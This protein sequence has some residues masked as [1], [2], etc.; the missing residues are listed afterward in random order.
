VATPPG[1]LSN[2]YLEN[3]IGG[4]IHNATVLRPAWAEQA[5]GCPWPAAGAQTP[6]QHPLSAPLASTRWLRGGTPIP[7]VYLDQPYAQRR[8][9]ILRMD[10]TMSSHPVTFDSSARRLGYAFS[11]CIDALALYVVNHFLEWGVPVVTPAFA[12]ALW[13]LNLSLVTAIVMN[14]TF[15]GYDA[16]SWRRLGQ[17][18]MDATAALS[19]YVLYLVFPFD[20]PSAWMA[21]ILSLLL[22]LLT[23]ALAISTLVRIGQGVQEFTD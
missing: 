19:T 20:L 6:H 18:A 16:P 14:A 7:F 15:I 3:L 1:F 17:A 23:A 21:S 13:A 2:G 12:D 8:G 22:L 10:T 11:A 5:I 4:D 9:L